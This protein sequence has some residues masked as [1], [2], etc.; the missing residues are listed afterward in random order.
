MTL[1]ED[2]L[3]LVRLAKAIDAETDQIRVVKPRATY[4][5]DSLVKAL[6]FS[7]T[8]PEQVQD[9]TSRVPLGDHTRRTYR[10][11]ATLLSGLFKTISVLR[12]AAEHSG[13]S[14]SLDWWIDRRIEAFGLFDEHVLLSPGS[15]SDFHTLVSLEISQLL[16]LQ[17]R[18]ILQNVTEN[19]DQLSHFHIMR[20]PPHDGLSPLWRPITLGHE[21]AHIW[22]RDE[23]VRSWL[24]SQD[25]KDTP[26][27]VQEAISRAIGARESGKVLV[28]WFAQLIKWLAEV[29]CD[30]AACVLYGEAGL[31]ALD[32]FWGMYASKSHT[33][34]HPS[35]RLR[36]TLQA[37]SSDVE[38]R[39]WVPRYPNESDES[40]VLAAFVPLA[41]RI[42][43]YV[44]EV[45]E[46]VAPTSRSI[47]RE[48]SASV[49]PP[50]RRGE[51]PPSDAWDA[52][53]VADEPE[54]VEC[55][56]VDGMWRVRAEALDQGGELKVLD[57]QVAQVEH[58]LD[59]VEFAARFR[60]RAKAIG[61]DLPDKPLPNVLYVSSE[62]VRGG[63]TCE[64]AATADLR[65]GRHFVVFQRNEIPYL[66]AVGKPVL[67]R[68]IQREV[69]VGWGESFVLHPSELVLAVT[70][71]S[72]RLTDDVCA[73]VLSR[74]SLGRLG[75]LSATAVQVQPSWVGCLTLELVNLSSVPLELNPGQRV[76]Q[77]VPLPVMGPSVPYDGKYQNAG[78]KP[79]FSLGRQDWEASILRELDN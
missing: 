78:P 25:L 49:L 34:S 35:P 28:P 39:E 11:A 33:A 65:L 38:L 43:D 23:V 48:I 8:I 54:S 30:T 31:R 68:S 79:Q 57:R 58:A 17:K 47:T 69:E 70:F 45:L 5:H 50:L 52:E 63:P 16:N 22:L 12:H 59:A 76:A 64:L 36:V 55:A 62:G 9:F 66:S 46:P 56:L 10:S 3:G 2:A 60:R 74:S 41:V 21:V 20:I 26:D 24:A 13:E 27:L 72:L 51:L 77:I 7:P 6:T 73:Q 1:H 37:D 15:P 75:L 44:K 29:G 61:V 53:G 67:S 19:A 32:Q 71:E 40:R 18:G 14:T 4:P 42:R